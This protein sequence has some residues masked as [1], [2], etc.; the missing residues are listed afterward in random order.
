MITLNARQK[1]QLKG[2]ANTLDA[3]F[4]VGKN[5]ISGNTIEMID[6]ALEAHELIK[7]SVLKTVSSPIR[8]IAFDLSAGTN[9]VVVQII[10]HVIVLY[11]PNHEKP[12]HIVLVK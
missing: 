7:V 8:E 1:S 9:S 2:I 5:E 3:R 11:R 12:N 6:K 4:Q 10:G